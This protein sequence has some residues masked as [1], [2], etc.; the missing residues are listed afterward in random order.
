VERLKDL[1]N[2]LCQPSILFT[3]ATV[4]FFVSLK[5]RLLWTR[6]AL[7]F[8]A[9]VF[10]VYFAWS[11]TDPDFFSIVAKPDNVP[12]TAMLFLIPFFW[13]LAMHLGYENDRRIAAGQGPMEGGE[14][15]DRIL[16][17]PDLVYTEMLC[18]IVCT[19]VLVAWSILLEA[20]IEEPANPSKSPNPSKAPWYFLGLQEMLVYFDPW[21]AGVVFPG[22]IIVGLMAIPYLDYNKK[23][24][25][26]Y[27]FKEREWEI[28]AYLY[29]FILLW[30][31]LIIYGTMLRGPNWNFFGP[32]EYWD[33]HK[34]EALV[35]INLSEI[36]YVKLL[37]TG[38]PS[39]W[40]FREIWGIAIVLIY[41]G[42]LPPLL[43]RTIFKR[44]FDNMGFVRYNTLCFL[45]LSMAALPIK[46]YLRWL[47]NLK[48]IVAIPEYFFNI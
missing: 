24:N 22:L 40:L 47:F 44:F 6:T 19:I 10:T 15:K 36:I 27:T 8:G 43:A 28:T 1:I 37:G 5:I 48:Y 4:L 18:L 31:M 7:Y 14:G 17:W 3:L 21:L 35:N 46:M 20:P 12:I 33:L 9:T 25:G 26:Y 39:F 32:Y 11:M 38:L 34:L 30:V 42:V 13:W 41:F 16:V 2:W 29:G 23:G 45:V